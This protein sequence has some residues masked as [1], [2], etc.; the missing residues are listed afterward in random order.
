VFPLTGAGLAC[1]FA[2]LGI[3]VVGQ[4]FAL[5]TLRLVLI[6]AGAWLA[7]TLTGSI[8]LAFAAVAIG[9]GTFAAGLLAVMRSH[10]NRLR[11]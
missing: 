4:P 5:A 1:Y 8:T 3:G 9:I 10:F 7:L 2:C 11:G 6:V